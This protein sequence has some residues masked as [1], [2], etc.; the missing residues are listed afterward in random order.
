MSFQL[1]PVSQAS[2]LI[3]LL[4]PRIG[5]N[6]RYFQGQTVFFLLRGCRLN[7]LS[8]MEHSRVEMLLF[9]GSMALHDQAQR[10]SQAP[11]RTEHCA[12]VAY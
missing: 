1:I 3:D 12:S 2:T 11:Q 8:S 5:K 6:L 9:G 10:S 4:T 7:L